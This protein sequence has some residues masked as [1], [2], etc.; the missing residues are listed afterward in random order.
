[1]KLLERE[2]GGFHV[3]ADIGCHTF[4]TLPPFNIGNTV[5]G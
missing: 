3:S 2:T 5:L 1:M 4:S